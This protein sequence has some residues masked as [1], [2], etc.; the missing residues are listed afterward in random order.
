MQITVTNTNFFKIV[1]I[2]A[3]L[4]NPY[5]EIVKSIPTNL[6]IEKTK[7]VDT[8]V[9]YI[10]ADLDL[11]KMVG[12]RIEIMPLAHFNDPNTIKFWQEKLKS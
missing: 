8:D 2:F 1:E 3:V 7:L 9:V 12:E 5:G 4:R 10:G 11:K 6:Y